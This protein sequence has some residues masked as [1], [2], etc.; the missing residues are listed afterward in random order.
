VDAASQLPIRVCAL[1]SQP[2]VAQGLSEAFAR[3]GS[4]M[5]AG[6][7]AAENEVAV[8]LG[9]YQPRLL[10]VDPTATGGNLLSLASRISSASR[11]VSTLV[12]N[13][14]LSP[15]EKRLI[16]GL[17]VA[18]MIE[19]HLPTPELIGLCLQIAGTEGPIA[20]RTA[21]SDLERGARRLTPKESEVARLASSGLK[22]REIAASMGIA[23]G[24]VKVHLMHVFEKTGLRDRQQLSGSARLFNGILG[25]P[26]LSNEPAA[27]TVSAFIAMPY[28]PA[29]PAA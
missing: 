17:G 11:D 21:A 10:L 4:L 20:V 26:T 18:S 14:G 7:C 27:A 23:Q 13:E 1:E 24:T 6:W 5:L 29:E 16:G 15:A 8:M 9:R 19:R 2:I 3:H 22:N 28:P 25:D 12:W